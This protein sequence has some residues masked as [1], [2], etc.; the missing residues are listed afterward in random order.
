MSYQR[1][2]REQEEFDRTPFPFEYPLPPSQFPIG[3]RVLVD[4]RDEALVKDQH[5]NGCTSQLSP[6][7][8]VS[9]VEGDENVRVPWGSVGVD[10][11]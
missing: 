8:H 1:S 9:F 10:R 7:Y 2:K 6:H 3:A 11:K 5:Y 4:G